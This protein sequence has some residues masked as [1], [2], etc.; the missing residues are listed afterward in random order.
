MRVELALFELSVTDLAVTVTWPPVGT[1]AG[2]VYIV[3]IPLAVEGRLNNP[4]ASAGAQ[5]QATPACVLSFD[6]VAE[7]TAVPPGTTLDDSGDKTTEMDRD[8]VP[9]G[10][11][12]C[13]ALPPQPELNRAKI[14][15]TSEKSDSPLIPFLKFIGTPEFGRGTFPMTLGN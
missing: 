1:I 7:T 10:V 15:A 6:T 2:A 11:P 13:E 12:D 4:Q 8:C 14:I 3:A 9:G 5:L